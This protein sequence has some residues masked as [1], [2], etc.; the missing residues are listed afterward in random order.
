MNTKK[1][2]LAI[3]LATLAVGT[4]ARTE[5]FIEV[6]TN[7]V[8]GFQDTPMQP[9]GKWHVHNPARSQPPVVTPGRF[10]DN[11]TPPSDEMVLFDGKDLA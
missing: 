8:A 4:T 11:A 9:D 7:G 5:K 3:L 2:S 1:L 10:S 6:V